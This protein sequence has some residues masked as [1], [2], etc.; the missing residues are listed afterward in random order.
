MAEHYNAKITYVL[1]PFANWL[2]DRLL[3]D[4]EK[5]VFDI[6][7]RTG[8]KNWRILSESI[9]GL[10]RWYSKELSKVCEEQNINYYDSNNFL[11]KDFG[12][13]IFVDR[14][15][16]TDFGNKIISNFIMEKI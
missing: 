1:Q 6:L 12:E 10:H 7:D 2:P 14:V 15:H 4:N 8:G 5:H 13:D 16:L 9:N 11:N 3:T